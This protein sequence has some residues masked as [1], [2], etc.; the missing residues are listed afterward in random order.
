MTM[1]ER[2]GLSAEV[3]GRYPHEFSG[4]QCRRIGIARA[5]ILGPRFAEYVMVTTVA[6]SMLSV[7]AQIVNLLTRLRRELDLESAVTHPITI[8]RVVRH[9]C[10]RVPVL[11]LDAG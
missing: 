4:G 11:Y 1:L 7:Q 8:S 5:V 3:P 2:V 10:Q 6:H 9:L